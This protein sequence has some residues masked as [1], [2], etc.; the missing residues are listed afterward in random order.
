MA[1]GAQ[2]YSPCLVLHSQIDFSCSV[3]YFPFFFPIELV[4]SDKFYNIVKGWI[5]KNGMTKN[6]QPFNPSADWR[7]LK[8]L[9]K[10][11][12]SPELFT[13]DLGMKDLRRLAIKKILDS[14]QDV[15]IKLRTIGTSLSVAK[16]NYYDKR[17]H[18]LLFL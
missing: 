17:Y 18:F 1:I 12:V 13:D 9:L 6:Q 7:K 14:G 15:D 10:K 3:N 5:S 16:K 11:M 2:E 4:W 8:G